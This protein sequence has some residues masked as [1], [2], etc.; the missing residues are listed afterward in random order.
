MSTLS[1]QKGRYYLQFSD[2][3]RSPRRVN[4]SLK[5][6]GRRE[7]QHIKSLMDS[8]YARGTWDPWVDPMWPPGRPQDARSNATVATLGD[9]L[10][11][12]KRS[13]AGSRKATRDHY[14][15]ILGAFVDFVGP[16]EGVHAIT[17]ETIGAW[18]QSVSTVSLNPTTQRTYWNCVGIFV[19]WRVQRGWLESDVSK[20]VVLLHNAAAVIFCHNHPSGNPEP[21][22]EDIAITR[23]L[24]EAGVL[25]DI[26]VRDH[27]VVVPD[28]SFTS[29]AR[30][31]LI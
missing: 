2:S 6:S 4:R 17:S 13:R 24:V 29:F 31:G 28:G 10:E 11:A 19:R 26:P 8:D 23:K 22:H 14:R 20:L 15:W 25:L 18:L 21:S 7:A 9:A 5:T 30:R 12:F 16:G 1:L 27:L 3:K